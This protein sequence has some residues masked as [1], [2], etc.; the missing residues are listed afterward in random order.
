MEMMIQ[1]KLDDHF[2]ILVLDGGGCK[3]I[4]QAAILRGIER[5]TGKSISDTFDLIVGSSV[6]AILGSVL[7]SGKVSAADTY[8]EMTRCIPYLFSRRMWPLLPKYNRNRFLPSW[9]RM[10]LS[11]VMMRDC[12]SLYMCTAMSYI[13]NQTHFFKSWHNNENGRPL[14]D[15]QIRSWAAPIFFGKVVDEDGV[16]ADGGCGLYNCPVQY[17]FTQG[18][19]LGWIGKEK[20][21]MLSIGTGHSVEQMSEEQ[22][23][24]ASNMRQLFTFFNLDSGGWARYESAMQAVKDVQSKIGYVPGFSF[25]RVDSLIPKKLD[26]LDNAAALGEYEKIGTDLIK[27]VDLRPLM[28]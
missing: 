11:G 3:G 28:G 19:R 25:Q 22:A 10:G 12:K 7:A 8:E 23:R 9:D 20:V 14:Y 2:N 1:K 21:H 4:I 13:D 24:K 18:M 17:A 16:W 6:G 5:A 15:V 27:T 26:K